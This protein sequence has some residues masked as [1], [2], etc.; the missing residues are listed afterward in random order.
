MK[1]EEIPEKNWNRF[2][3][4][5]YVYVR[6]TKKLLQNFEYLITSKK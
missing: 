5:T 6:K 4:L 3:K 1:K 2:E